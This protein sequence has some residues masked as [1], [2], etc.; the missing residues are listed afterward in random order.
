MDPIVNIISGI[1]GGTIS[2]FFITYIV[3]MISGRNQKAGNIT[4]L[5]LFLIY[6]SSVI[7]LLI[8]GFQFSVFMATF[9][10]RIGPVILAYLLFNYLVGGSIFYKIR[11]KKR[12][13]TLNTDIQT[14]R[15]F[16]SISLITI[17]GS[18][19]LINLAYFLFEDFIKYFV[20][21]LSL[22]SLILMIILMFK[23]KRL[24]LEKVILF[25]GKNKEFIYSYEISKDQLKVTIKDFF[26]NEMY[27]VDA[28]GEVELIDMDKSIEKNYLFWIATGEKID[29]KDEN[30]TKL[31]VLLYKDYLDQFEKYHYKKVTYHVT[32]T[33]KVELVKEKLIK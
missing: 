25:V 21:A 8:Q 2:V 33:N 29:M 28:I 10:L 20:I 23:N 19:I 3:Y 24:K 18:V 31:D 14:K 17:I 1:L 30:L 15:V 7:S 27:I 22:L 6:F 4:I 11:I 9:L 13:K 16:Q 12:L 32:K 26:K 5:V